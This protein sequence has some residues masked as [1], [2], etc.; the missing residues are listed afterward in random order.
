[1]L[2]SGAITAQLTGPDL[3]R[4][5]V[6]GTELIRRINFA[7]RDPL[8]GTVQPASVE[9][10]IEQRPD[11]LTISIQAVHRQGPIWFEWTGLCEIRRTGTISYE[12]DGHHRSNYVYARIGLN[13]L[14]PPEVTAGAPFRA[15]G[16]EGE[17]SGILPRTIGPQ[18][19]VDG[20]VVPLFPP[21]SELRLDTGPSSLALRFDGSLFEM[22]D[23]RNWTDD[24][25]KT[26]SSPPSLQRPHRARRDERMRQRIEIRFLSTRPPVALLR[27]RSVVLTVG[28]PT[29]THVPG[30]GVSMNGNGK[31]PTPG[32]LALLR[33]LRLGHLRATVSPDTNGGD[34]EAASRLAKGLACPLELAVALDDRPPGQLRLSLRS[35]ARS[36]AVDRVLLTAT[37]PEVLDPATFARAK[38]VVGAVFPEAAVAGGTS[39]HF[40]DLNRDPDNAPK[41]DMVV[42]PICP[43]AHAFDETSLVEGL[44]AQGATVVAARETTG[45]SVV[46]SP[47]TFARPPPSQARTDVSQ[48]KG[49]PEGVDRRQS[50]QFLA[51]WTVGSV[52][53]LSEAGVKAATYFETI[54]W[55][56]IID[57]DDVDHP[58]FPSRPGLVFPVYHVLADVCGW[59]GLRVLECS[60]TDPLA[61]VGLAVQE[62]AGVGLLIANL[63]PFAQT[64]GVEPL[65]NAVELRHLGFDSIKALDPA[66]AGQY[67]QRWTW[68]DEPGTDLDIAPYGVLR[69][70][71]TELTEFLAGPER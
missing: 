56:G 9:T 46:V 2:S 71:P 70:S 39:G 48:N 62:R 58:D 51:A 61:V 17:A 69:V 29:G 27:R 41:F 12:F 47:I 11:G 15:R 40:V 35:I 13:V 1:M 54:G 30:L 5:C 55:R 44:V 37:G 6:N 25:F 34:V 22:E 21:M 28:G 45:G 23:Q 66:T 18:R 20:S 65:S 43:Q 19:V 14:H 57:Q 67:R 50:T 32:Q 33:Q 7:V 52:K 36:T 16:P 4:I 8:W 68:L 64:V 42:Y 59:R 38:T 26:Y 49:L 53:Y 60:S 63:T 10:E 31:V 3:R 24:S